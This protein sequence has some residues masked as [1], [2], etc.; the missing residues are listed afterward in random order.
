MVLNFRGFPR[1][2]YQYPDKDLRI[3]DN[4][5][6]DPRVK[7]NRPICGELESSPRFPGALVMQI[8]YQSFRIP[9]QIIRAEFVIFI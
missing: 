5:L 4:G 1:N 8:E 7:G 2:F 6:L 9:M 3:R